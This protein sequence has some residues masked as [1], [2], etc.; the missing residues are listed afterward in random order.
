MEVVL[1]VVVSGL[2]LTAIYG[3]VAIGLSLT[4]A[5]LGFLNLAHAVVFAVAAY[6]AWAVATYVTP[7]GP[8]VLTS[9]VVAGAMGGAVIYLLVF[10]PLDGKPE[11]LMRTLMATLALNLIGV[12]ALLLVFG[13]RIKSLPPI[14]GKGSLKIGGLV[15]TADF[16]GSALSAT[17][18]LGVVL[19]L[20]RGSRIGLGVRVLV[21]NPE[22]ALLSGINRH[23][24]ALSVLSVSGGLAGAAAV[25]LGRTFFVSP[26]V[27]F[28]PLIKGLIV[29]LLGGLGSIPG[30]IAAAALV[31]FVDAVTS[32]TLGNQ[33]VLVSLFALI[34]V[35][36]W[37][38]PR[39]LGG[40]LETFR[41]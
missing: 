9:G 39:G 21:Q 18:L 3:L 35:V 25:L 37:L 8:L 28:V 26:D 1:R 12:N 20:L 31:G 10:R 30:T 7:L 16:L 23:M 29:T 11:W 24:I 13:P 19:A 27:G 32:A 36:L 38:R 6:G 22:G 41:A 34:A 40:L 2:N 33:Y 5:S 17:F 15:L 4:W 14:F